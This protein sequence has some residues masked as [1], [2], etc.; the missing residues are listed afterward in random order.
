MTVRQ[1]ASQPF[2]PFPSQLLDSPSE[3]PKSQENV[4][5]HVKLMAAA[6]TRR[7]RSLQFTP[8]QMYDPAQQSRLN[9][10]MARLAAPDRACQKIQLQEV[11]NDDACWGNK[12]ATVVSLAETFGQNG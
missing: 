8:F 3:V 6:F 10:K 9:L 5:K 1:S 2:A 7:P 12:H 4:A 11:V